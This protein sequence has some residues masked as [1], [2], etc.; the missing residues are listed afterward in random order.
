LSFLLW[1]LCNSRKWFSVSLYPANIAW[2]FI[3]VEN[4]VYALSPVAH[5]VSSERDRNQLLFML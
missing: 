1:Y 5:W 2:S 4:Y 3:S